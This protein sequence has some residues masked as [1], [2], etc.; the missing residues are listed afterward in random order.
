MKNNRIFARTIII[1]FIIFFFF[2]A[3]SSNIFAATS[4]KIV[5][6]FTTY[7]FSGDVASYNSEVTNHSSL[8]QIATATYH[9]DGSGNILGITPSNQISYAN[10]NNIKPFLLLGNSFSPTISQSLLEST[11]NTDKAISNLINIL[12]N[13][14]YKGVNL[15]FEG[16]NSSERNY[17]TQ[18]VQKVYNSLSPLGYIV[19]V[20]LPPKTSDDTSNSLTYPYDYA[21]IA[22]YADYVD[23]MTYDQH[24]PTGTHG[25]IASISWVNSVINYALT[26][27]PKNKIVLGLAAYGYDWSIGSTSPATAYSIDGCYSLAKKYNAQIQWDPTSGSCYFNYT[28]SSEH[29]HSVWSE[30]SNSI[31]YKLQSVNSYELGG[32]A[33]WKLGFDNTAYWET[34][35]SILYKHKSTSCCNSYKSINR[36]YSMYNPSSFAS[37]YLH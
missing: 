18:F 22:K 6:G 32:I 13:S 27:I 28:D 35:N 19:S 20:S 21:N 24:C 14:G 4:S 1:C 36:W 16:I 30:D 9:V 10:D 8:T 37:S 23:I 33:I 12:K 2:T 11:T 29:S 5:L 26:V 25:S 34:I 7:Y 3:T 17:Y 15:D 31:S